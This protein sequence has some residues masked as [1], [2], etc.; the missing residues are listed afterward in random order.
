MESFKERYEEA[1]RKRTHDQN[2]TTL[3]HSGVGHDDNPPGRG[4]GR[5]PYGSGKRPFQDREASKKE[6]KD[7]VKGK[8]KSQIFSQE[9]KIS[10]GTIM[11]RTTAN[12]ESLKAGQSTYVTYLEPDR[13]LYRSGYQRGRGSSVQE[14]KFKLKEDL[15]IPSNDTVKDVVLDL[16]Q[17]DRSLF[18]DSVRSYLEATIPE[19]SDNRWYITHDRDTDEER[20]GAWESFIKGSIRDRLKEPIADQYGAFM[21]SL[22]PSTKL[23]NAVISELKKMGYT[24]MQDEAGVHGTGLTIEGIDPLIIFDASVLNQMSVSTINPKDDVRY[25]RKYNS[26]HY[27]VRD[28]YRSGTF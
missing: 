22:G 16:V 7:A 23:K 1:I 26:W 24:A 20:P 5:Y 3:S 2:L 15:K 25:R 4:S 27:N 28:R 19:W 13:N 6:I 14:Y 9:R 10:A 11:Y 17:K 18:D 21:A 8:R 12:P